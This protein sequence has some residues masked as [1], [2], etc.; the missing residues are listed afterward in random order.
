M[1][2][3][4]LYIGLSGLDT[5]E[6]VLN[7]IGE[8]IANANTPGYHRQNA[9]L[10]EQTPTPV[11][12]LQLGSG[13]DLAQIQRLQDALVDQSIRQQTAQS[14]STNSQLSSLQQIQ[15][16]LTPGS[17]SLDSLLQNFFSQ[18]QQLSATPDDLTQRGVFLRSAADLTNQLN[19][20]AANFSQLGQ[21]ID[22]QA[23]QLV[24][25]ANGLASQIAD[26]NGQI[27]QLSSRGIVPS[28]QLDQ[29]DQLVNQL[30]T[31][32]DVRVVQQQDGE[33]TVLAGG[34]PV[35]VG[36]QANALKFS[37]DPTGT[38]IVTAA[39]STSPLNL[40]GGQLAGLLTVRNQ[41]L[42]AFQDKL[43]TL[44]HGLAQSVNA[45]HAAGVGLSGS[46]SFLAG[47]QAV[48]SVNAPLA[49]ANLA[50]P[51]HAGSLFVTVTNQATGART[52]SQINI[53]PATQSLQDVATALNGVAHLQ[54]IA[55]ASTGTLKILAQPGYTF[56]FTGRSSSTPDTV[57]V[58]G[59]TTVQVGG[60]YT[61]TS[62]DTLTYKV[63]GT[64]TIGVTPN[65]SL[66]VSNVAGAVVNTLNIGQGYSP[67]SDLPVGNGLTIQLA[68]GTANA[69]D[70]FT[71]KVVGQSDT[72]GIL[73]A[74]GINSFFTGDNAA[75]IAV[76]P[77]LLSH[78]EQLAAAATGQVGDGT[79]LQKLAALNNAPVLNNGTQTFNQFYAAIVGNVGGQVQDLTQRQSAEQLVGQNLQAQQQAVSG[80]NPNE[81]L[82]N[83]LQFQRAYQISAKYIATVNS[84][85]DD[86]LAL[87]K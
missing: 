2:I 16:S 3:S 64:G 73:P 53:D 61:G 24:T 46:F 55:D 11:G 87:V 6:Q 30:A 25:Q 67:G 49:Q 14:N 43:N 41:S 35:A 56:D 82:V 45:I 9:L 12:N 32:I 86:L 79:I 85:M 78:P 54:G 18:L 4:N 81:E 47:S 31:I 69:G 59:T 17:G 37:I 50:F 40:A 84:T 27:Q 66:Q 72:A 1:S 23:N 62:N 10:V 65:L 71:T 19:S 75:N 8:N 63:V 52:L 57:A 48:R 7:V 76:S 36:T 21:Y 60:N 5:A 80:V 58:T 44:A 34:T 33:V 77:D 74:L 83:M 42:P 28:T 20:L 70:T 26:L 29:R 22:N 38:A 51:P 13:V 68:A 39:G 15:A